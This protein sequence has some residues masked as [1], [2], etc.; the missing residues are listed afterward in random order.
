MGLILQKKMFNSFFLQI[1]E[2][3]PKKG[4]YWLK[5]AVFWPS[6]NDWKQEENGGQRKSLKRYLRTIEN[7]ELLAFNINSLSSILVA[8]NTNSTFPSLGIVKNRSMHARNFEK[9]WSRKQKQN[10]E[11]KTTKT[12]VWKK[13][14]DPTKKAV[15]FYEKLY[16]FLR[17][18][19]AV[20]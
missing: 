4:P 12:V 5:N 18:R 6:A 7:L 14:Q 2:V 15:L 17:K 8:K 3:F 13:I 9:K 10:C 19:L 16:V 20:L 11:N 1:C